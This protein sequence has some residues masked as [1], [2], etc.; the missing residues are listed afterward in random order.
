MRSANLPQAHRGRCSAGSRRRRGSQRSSYA[1]AP[2]SRR[3]SPSRSLPYNLIRIP[4]LLAA[5]RHDRATQTPK[6]LPP[7]S[8]PRPNPS[9][10]PQSKSSPRLV[11]PPARP[12][13]GCSRMA[14]L[15]AGL[16][17]SPDALALANTGRSLAATDKFVGPAGSGSTRSKRHCKQGDLWS[18]IGYTLLCH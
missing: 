12:A 6:P 1:D 4:K 18:R 3:P 2:R 5:K 13:S 9:R 8:T 17:S 11:Q 10:E 16:F 7:P 15:G 14:F